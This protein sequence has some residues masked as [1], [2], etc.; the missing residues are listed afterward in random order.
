MDPPLELAGSK[1]P[2][3]DAGV[4]QCGVDRKNW[5][6]SGPTLSRPLLPLIFI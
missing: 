6:E 2:V 5:G 4:N 3:V 1:L